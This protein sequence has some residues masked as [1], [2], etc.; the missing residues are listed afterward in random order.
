MKKTNE[1][2]FDLNW[3]GKNVPIDIDLFENTNIISARSPEIL[4]FDEVFNRPHIYF[5]CDTSD[6]FY[7]IEE[8]PKIDS[9]SHQQDFLKGI[10]AMASSNPSVNWPCRK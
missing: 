6:Y 1:Y 2:R 3:N 5:E 8:G 9:N 4:T 7:A 10:I